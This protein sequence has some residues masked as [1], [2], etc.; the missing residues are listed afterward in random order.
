[1]EKEKLHQ[2]LHITFDGQVP[3]YC[4]GRCWFLNANQLKNINYYVF[5]NGKFGTPINID[6]F[7]LYSAIFLH[8][9]GYFS[10]CNG[11]V[12]ELMTTF[13]H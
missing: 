6:Q 7:L 11:K 1:M 2:V 12:P 8:I 4:G 3:S 13:S 10:L 5:L 9:P